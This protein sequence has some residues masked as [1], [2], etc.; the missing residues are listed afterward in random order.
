MRKIMEFD[1]LNP[2][3][4]VN[5][6][7]NVQCVVVQAKHRDLLRVLYPHLHESKHY[8]LADRRILSGQCR[9]R[10]NLQSTIVVAEHDVIA[11][12]GYLE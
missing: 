9:K 3:D 10:S 11:Q 1:M 6:F 2:R 12:D 8:E 7:L 4:C 5:F